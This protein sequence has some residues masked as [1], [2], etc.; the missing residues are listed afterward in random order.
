[1]VLDH[2]MFTNASQNHTGDLCHGQRLWEKPGYDALGAIREGNFKLVIG[3]TAEASWFGRFSPNNTG[4]KPDLLATDCVDH[5][6]LYN[7]QV[8]AN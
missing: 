7:V 6:C 3:D 1:M 8:G 5:Q 2:R 4:V